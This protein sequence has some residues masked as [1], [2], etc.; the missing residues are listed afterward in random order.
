MPV[1][2]SG[3]ICFFSTVIFKPNDFYLQVSAKIDAFQI[4]KKL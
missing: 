4:L 3:F 1:E 2:I